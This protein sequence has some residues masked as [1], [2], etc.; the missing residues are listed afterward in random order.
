MKTEDGRCNETLSQQFI[1][2]KVLEVI[3]FVQMP[4]ITLLLE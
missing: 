4:I 1:Y 3:I 2:L